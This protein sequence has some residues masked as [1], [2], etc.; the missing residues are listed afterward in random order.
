M[1]LGGRKVGDDWEGWWWSQG[2][3]F[4]FNR[5]T[6]TSSILLFSFDSFIWHSFVVNQIKVDEKIYTRVLLNKIY[7]VNSIHTHDYQGLLIFQCPLLLTRLRKISKNI[8]L[9]Y[10]CTCGLF[11]QTKLRNRTP[12]VKTFLFFDLKR[13][14]KNIDF[15]WV[16]KNNI[17]QINAL[18]N[19]PKNIYR[20]F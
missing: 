4:H 15:W 1:S 10:T 16:K 8:Y 6:F 9:L 7:P 14:N 18:K 19:I 2:K 20:K 5:P 17:V 12:R 11:I 13:N 3:Y